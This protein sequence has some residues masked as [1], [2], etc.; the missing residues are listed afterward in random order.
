M[1]VKSRTSSYAKFPFLEPSVNGLKHKIDRFHSQYTVRR[2]YSMLSRPVFTGPVVNSFN[3]CLLLARDNFVVIA[4]HPSSQ[5]N[6]ILHQQH[7]QRFA[8]ELPVD[9]IFAMPLS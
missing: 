1:S 5:S 8:L 4:G 3:P 6:I 2:M 7:Q 9:S